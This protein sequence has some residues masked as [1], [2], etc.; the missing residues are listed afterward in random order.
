MHADAEWG[1]QHFSKTDYKCALTGA[2]E[3]P[4]VNTRVGVN[5]IEFV[6]YKAVIGGDPRPAGAVG[7]KGSA[8]D[9]AAVSSTGV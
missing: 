5:N 8:L 4:P 6:G 2:Q 1:G 9:A 7:Q 3:V